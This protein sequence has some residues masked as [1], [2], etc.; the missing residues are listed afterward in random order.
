MGAACAAAV[1]IGLRM[2]HLAWAFDFGALQGTETRLVNAKLNPV[3]GDGIVCGVVM[4][5]ESATGITC[6]GVREGKRTTYLI[7]RL[8]Q[9]SSSTDYLM[10]AISLYNIVVAAD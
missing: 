9:L 2:V 7:T 10:K 8:V 4:N 5:I 6:V 1:V 3:T